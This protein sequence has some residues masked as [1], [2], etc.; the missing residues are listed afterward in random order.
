MFAG[1]ECL[2]ATL[3]YDFE[4]AQAIL[5]L[6]TFVHCVA[7]RFR[8]RFFFAFLAQIAQQQLLELLRQRLLFQELLRAEIVFGTVQV[9]H[10]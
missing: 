6:L 3:G 8:R 2:S 1:R 5:K 9:R 7:S 4:Q 10:H